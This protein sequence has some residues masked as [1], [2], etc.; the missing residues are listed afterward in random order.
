MSIWG[1]LRP[2]NVFRVGIAYLVM[3]WLVLQI[4]D[5]VSEPLNLPD[6]FPMVVILLLAVGFPIALIVNRA[7]ELTPEGL[8][9]KRGCRSG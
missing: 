6:W 5:V 4:V 7:F 8:E 2:R 9:I 3:A 1:E